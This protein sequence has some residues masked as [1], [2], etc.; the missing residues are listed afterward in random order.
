[1]L[2]RSVNGVEV[3]LSPKEEA[4]LRADW[5]AD[6]ARRMVEQRKAIAKTKRIIALEKVLEKLL[7]ENASI[8]E[9]RDYLDSK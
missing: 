9:V 8:S 4:D 6:D 5:A 3:P 7:E 1:M 2:K